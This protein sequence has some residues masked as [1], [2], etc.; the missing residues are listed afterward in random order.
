MFSRLQHNSRAAGYEVPGFYAQAKIAQRIDA[1]QNT[2]LAEEIFSTVAEEAT[3]VN[4]RPY[5]A[6]PL[7]ETRHCSSICPDSRCYVWKIVSRCGFAS[8]VRNRAQPYI[9][10]NFDSER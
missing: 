5:V 6:A 1:R 9:L 8:N 3:D 10:R 4:Q 2:V 7:I